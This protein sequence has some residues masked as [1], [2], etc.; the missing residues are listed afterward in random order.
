MRSNQR[1]VFFVFALLSICA[2]LTAF[3]V[4]A[5]KQNDQAE[6]RKEASQ[7]PAAQQPTQKPTQKPAQKDDE[8]VAITERTLVEKSVETK[9]LAS[10]EFGNFRPPI[11]NN[12]GEIAF[13]SLFSVPGSKVGYSQSIFV[14]GA[15]GSWKITKEGEKAANMS[16]GIYGFGGLLAFN[17]RGDLTFIADFGDGPQKETPEADPND[18]LAA[19]SPR[20]NKSIFLKTSDGLK[21]LTKLGD[22][23]PAMPSHF[24]GYANASTNGKGTTAFI[25][26]YSDPDGRGLFLIEGGKLR[27]VCRSGQRI[28]NGEDGTFSEHYYPSHINERDEVAFLARI[29]DKSGIF[30]SRPKGIEL[31]TIS[32]KPSPIKTANFIGFGNRTPAISDNGEVAFVGF[33]DGP[34]AGRGLFSKGDGPTKIVAK[35]GDKIGDTNYAFTDFLYPAINSRG[36]IAF[37]GK[38]GGRNQAIFLKTAKGLEMIAAVDQPVPNGEKGETFNNFQPPSIN[39]QGVVVFYAQTKNPKTGVDLGIFVRDEKGNVKPLVR[40]G[41]KMPK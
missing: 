22:E 7:T 6:K 1:H 28:G 30:V 20:M 24:S 29:G 40:R 32:G 33:Y 27:I 31:I 3:G 37:L 18:P 15:D 8:P 36:D 19:H 9:K 21:S 23:V 41:D 38:Y 10:D 14:R 16:K 2:L 12:K 17:D 13:V 26:T 35:S 5:Q 34:N 39:D 4:N 25:G 11:V